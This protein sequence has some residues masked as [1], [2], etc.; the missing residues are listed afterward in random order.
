MSANVIDYL[1]YQRR[2]LMYFNRAEFAAGRLN[3][4]LCQNLLLSLLRLIYI[5]L[6]IFVHGSETV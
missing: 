2:L 4:G 3:K 1:C 6:Y 5:Y